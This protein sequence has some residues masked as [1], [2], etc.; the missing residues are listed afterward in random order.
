MMVTTMWAVS[1]WESGFWKWRHD[2]F[3]R[4]SL[5]LL[6]HVTAAFF[7]FVFV[8]LGKRTSVGKRP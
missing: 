7:V 5:L 1:T 6:D 4:N 3:A 8:F 2:V